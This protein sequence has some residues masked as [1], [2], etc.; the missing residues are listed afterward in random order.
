MLAK[1]VAHASWGLPQPSTTQVLDPVSKCP[2]HIKH[3]LVAATLGVGRIGDH[4][5][6]TF[7]TTDNYGCGMTAF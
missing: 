4:M 1:S 3:Q 6:V 7:I 5:C 2:A